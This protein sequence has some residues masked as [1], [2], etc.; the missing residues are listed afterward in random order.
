MDTE[1]SSVFPEQYLTE[2]YQTHHPEPPKEEEGPSPPEK[3]TAILLFSLPEYQK[4]P[5]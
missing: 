5:I 2:S 3:Q 1:Q 4:A